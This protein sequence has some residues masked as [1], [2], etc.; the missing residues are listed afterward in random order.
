[1]TSTGA[2]QNQLLQPA[3][4]PA[5]TEDMPSDTPMPFSLRLTCTRARARGGAQSAQ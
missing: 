2:M 5:P 3:M 1:M 4:P